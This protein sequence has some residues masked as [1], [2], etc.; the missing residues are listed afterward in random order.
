[1]EAKDIM[2][3]IDEADCNT[4]ACFRNSFGSPQPLGWAKKLIE[5]SFKAGED[6][7]RR[8]VVDFMC[9]EYEDEADGAAAKYAARN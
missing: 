6:K 2:D 3:I 8:E 9:I 4:D 5:I 7:G 1:M